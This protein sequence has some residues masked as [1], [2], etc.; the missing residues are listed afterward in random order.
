MARPIRLLVVDDSAVARAVL[1]RMLAA[2]PDFHVVAEASSAS[3]ALERLAVTRVDLILLDVEMPGTTGLDAL[4]RLLAA[5]R[6]ARVLV[7]S[8]L[9]ED[10]AEATV[11][12]LGLGAADTLP[13]PGAQNFGGRFSAVLA[14]R[15]RRLAEPAPVEP[16]A[17]ASVPLRR[18]SEAR[19]GCVAL[20][21]STGGLHAIGEL[22][23]ALPPRIGA[24]IL[25]AQHLPALFMPFFARQLES[26]SGRAVRVAEE[27]IPLKPDEILLAPGDAHLSLQRRGGKVI[28]IL[29]PA[30]APSGCLPSVD[31][32][33]EA[34]A[35]IYGRAGLGVVMS[36]MGRDGLAGARALAAKE[37]EILVQDRAS[38]AVWGMPRA[39]AEAGLAAAILPPAELAARIAERAG[40]ES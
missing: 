38:S 3:E 19:L 33:L 11:R 16:P 36:G 6:G 26:L 20:G 31:V 12:A 22:L 5:G 30:P 28:A 21:A 18:P 37:G 1:S 35:A 4:P 32:T 29:D 10:G 25:V 13:K 14:E 8:C 17:P 40:A 24:P 9:C 39:V 23:K 15:I 34:V 7:V 2:Q 27:G